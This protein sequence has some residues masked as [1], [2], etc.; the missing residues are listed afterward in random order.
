MRTRV[1]LFDKGMSLRGIGGEKKCHPYY[2]PSRGYFKRD[3]IR[4]TYG[5]VFWGFVS[6]RFFLLLAALLGDD[7]HGS[8]GAAVLI[9][10]RIGL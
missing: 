2:T 7:G 9:P 1:A 3:C 5:T 8:A 6:F 10:D 4:L